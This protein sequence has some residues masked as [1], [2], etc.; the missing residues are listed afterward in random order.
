MQAFRLN[1][2]ETYNWADDSIHVRDTM[3]NLKFTRTM[4]VSQTEYFGYQ[5]MERLNSGISIR[6]TYTIRETHER[7][8]FRK[9]N[10]ESM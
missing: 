5:I 10:N 4:Q 8:R 9:Q 7:I 6:A 2:R 1:S 3:M